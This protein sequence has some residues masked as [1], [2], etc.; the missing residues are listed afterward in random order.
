MTEKLLPRFSPKIMYRCPECG[1]TNLEVVVEVW[2][3]LSQ[4]EDNL[5]TD[6]STPKGGDHEWSDNSAMRCIV[7]GCDDIAERFAV[8]E[9]EDE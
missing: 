5:E 8:P 3:T 4:T 7:C 1:S 2:A 9:Q 6:T